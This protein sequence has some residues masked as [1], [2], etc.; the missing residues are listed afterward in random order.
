MDRISLEM[1]RPRCRGW[2]S[3]IAAVLV[4]LLSLSGMSFAE[5]DKGQGPI[6]IYGDSRYG[7]A[8]HERIVDAF[9]TMAPVA[10]FNT[11]DLVTKSSSVSQWNR[12]NEIFV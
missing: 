9:M 3:W 1:N 4:I 7:H 2:I 10:V 5:E 12:Y 8:I 6:V 11:G